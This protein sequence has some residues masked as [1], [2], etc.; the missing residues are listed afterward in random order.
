MADG[1][2]NLVY[3]T[4]LPN[5]RHNSNPD[6]MW[7]IRNYFSSNQIGVEVM[8]RMLITNHEDYSV[9]RV[10]GT[11]EPFF[12][13]TLEEA[14]I[15]VESIAQSDPH[16]IY[17]G[18]YYIDGPEP[19]ESRGVTLHRMCKSFDDTMWFSNVGRAEQAGYHAKRTASIAF[20]LH[21]ELREENE[22]VTTD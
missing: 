6:S 19:P 11:M 10:D 12:G 20:Y 13:L 4:G 16:G 15:A 22:Y 8:A 5:S 1:T 21:P 3:H 14:N 7:H 2:S 18:E 17:S 9:G